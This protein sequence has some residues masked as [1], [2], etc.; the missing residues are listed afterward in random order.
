MFGIAFSETDSP[1]EGYPVD[2][3]MKTVK[4]L[5]EQIVGVFDRPGQNG[6]PPWP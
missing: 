3:F 6:L 2:G 5:I 4:D 1:V